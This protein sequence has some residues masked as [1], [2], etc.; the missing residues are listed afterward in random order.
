MCLTF[1]ISYYVLGECKSKEIS[2]HDRDLLEVLYSAALNDHQELVDKILGETRKFSGYNQDCINIIL[3]LI[4]QKKEDAALK[5]FNSMKPA[6]LGDRQA[7]ASGGFFIRQL[8]KA[9]CA[10]EKIVSV[11]Q[12]LC[13]SGLNNRAFFRALE[14]A[15]SYGRPQIANAVL[16]EIQKQKDTLRPQ[17]FWPL[18][19]MSS[20]ISIFGWFI[21]YSLII[22]FNLCTDITI[23][24]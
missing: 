9:N 20:F 24:V 14:A 19:V 7:Q 5:V 23:K 6:L 15:N 18:L 2:L 4:N 1:T 22:M 10:P 16:K 12:S 13:D 17:A 11:C 3:R 21:L 8:V